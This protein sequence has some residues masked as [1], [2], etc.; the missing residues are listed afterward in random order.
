VIIK[1]AACSA[2]LGGCGYLGVMLGNRSSQ[3]TKQLREF[4][5]ALNLLEFDVDFLCMPLCESFDKIA[6]NCEGAVKSIFLNISENFKN[7]PCGDMRTCWRKAFELNRTKLYLN[8]EDKKIFMDFAKNLGTGNR[9]KEM[10]NIRTADARL[11]V[12]EEEAYVQSK[13][14]SK[15]YRGL[16]ILSGIFFVI[17]LV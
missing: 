16:G 15:L 1:A 8:D 6:K 11:K 7:S 2:I 4:R 3:R 14:D 5:K 10:N 9:E 12:A 17:I 13:K